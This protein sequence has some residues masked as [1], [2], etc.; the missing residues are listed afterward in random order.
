MSDGITVFRGPTRWLSNF[1]EIPI[2]FDGHEYKTV[3]HAYMAAKTLDWAEREA[4]RNCKTPGDAKRMGRTVT[5]RSDW[6][7]IKLPVMKM[8]LK[9][10]FSDPTLKAKLLETVPHELIEGNAWG[11]R[12]WGAE[13]DADEN[14]WVGQNLL[15]KAIMEI[16]ESY[17]EY[18][19]ILHL[20]NRVALLEGEIV[21]LEAEVEA[22]WEEK[23]GASL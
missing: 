14:Q 7:E 1:H 11:D 12:V 17:L 3:E 2:T 21:R 18:P 5:L 16:R 23:A 22:H 10:K 9:A 6:E 8:L 4:I 15:G 13:W 20:T 19:Q